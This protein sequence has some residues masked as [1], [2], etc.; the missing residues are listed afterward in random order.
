MFA[1][2]Y[3]AEVCLRIRFNHPLSCILIDVDHFKAINDTHGHSVGDQVLKLIA[4]VISDLCRTEDVACRF[5]GEEFVIIAPHTTGAT[6]A[7]RGPIRQMDR[8]HAVQA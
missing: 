3:E 5:G 8:R 6:R 4:G 7:F 1:Q 2:R